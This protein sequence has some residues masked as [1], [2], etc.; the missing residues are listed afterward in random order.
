MENRLKDILALNKTITLKVSFPHK[1]GNIEV[2]KTENIVFY[3]NQ[4]LLRGFRNFLLSQKDIHLKNGYF[5]YLKRNNKIIKELS[6]DTKIAELELENLDTIIISYD[7]LIIENNQ[8]LTTEETNEN[9]ETSNRILK[10]TDP[11]NEL[12]IISTQIDKI[13][14]RESNT[15]L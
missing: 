2:S 7:K 12:K 14:E 11:E 13:R 15:S 1:L 8:V 6:T 5:F 10:T 4:T 3:L 9:I